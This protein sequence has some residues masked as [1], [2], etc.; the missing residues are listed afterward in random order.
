MSDAELIYEGMPDL[1]P[2]TGRSPG[3]HVSTV[4]H[5]LA[6]GLGYLSGDSSRLTTTWAQLG[7]ALESSIIARWAEEYP[8]RFV[9]PGEIEKDG[10]FGTPDMLDTEDDSLV[11][12]K[13]SWMSSKQT[14]DS[15]KFWRYWVQV[16]AYCWM[17]GTDKGSLHVC[18]V[19]G[20]YKFGGGTG[21]VY[22]VWE[23]VFEKRELVEN[24]K[25]ILV[26]AEEI[27]DDSSG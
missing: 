24:W 8:G 10:I 22:R 16:M 25:M 1:L 20:D 21:P 26:N 13:L 14:A 19:N 11:E 18:H 12:I 5:S 27:G 3:M 9:Q 17:W 4:I 6:V 2:M 15:E 23:R 7:C